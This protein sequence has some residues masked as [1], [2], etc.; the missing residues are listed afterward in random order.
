MNILH[1]LKKLETINGDDLYCAETCRLH[2]EITVKYQ[3]DGID[4]AAPA[5]TEYRFKT[6][7]NSHSTNPRISSTEKQ[8]AESAVCSFNQPAH[9]LD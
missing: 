6:L 7:N 3:H 4:C 5:R 2:P 9:R 1:R 8:T